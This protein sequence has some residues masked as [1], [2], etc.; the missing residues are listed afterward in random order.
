MGFDSTVWEI[1]AVN[2]AVILCYMTAAWIVSLV[3]RD[4]GV[5]DIFWGPGFVL[6]AWLSFGLTEGYDCRKLII[7]ALATLWGLRLGGYIFI[8]NLG[9]PEDPRYTAIR[10][11][12]GDS[13]PL[14]S[15]FIIFGLQGVLLFIISLPLQL[16]QTAPVPAELTWFDLAGMAVWTAGFLF[17]AVADFQLYRFKAD[18]A[19]RGRV[20]DRGLWAWSRHPN[21]FG[22]TLV[23]WGLFIIALSTPL[24]PWT[25]A[26][27]LLITFLLLRVSGVTLLEKN[28]KKSKPRYDEYIR[29]TSAF[30][31]WFPR[32]GK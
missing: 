28:L 1:L 31:P 8:R 10:R 14:R 6:T 4:A 22:E 21:Y 20:M 15:L 5:A 30:I 26:S 18:P 23:W 19:N 17:E 2:G 12:H 29:K 7:T 13:F 9:K 25:A 11:R 32:K 24:G 3:R 16:A 27:P